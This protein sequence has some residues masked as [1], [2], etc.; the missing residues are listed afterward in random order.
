M[1]AKD[2]NFDPM[3]LHSYWELEYDKKWYQ[4]TKTSW[5]TLYIYYKTNIIFEKPNG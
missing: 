2:G 1:I 3:V 4:I 5:F